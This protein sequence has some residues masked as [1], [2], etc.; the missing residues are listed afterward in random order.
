MLLQSRMGE[1]HLLPALPATWPDGKVTGLRAR[2]GF[3]VDMEWKDGKL[4]AAAVQSLR[5]N[6]CRIR[7]GKTLRDVKIKEGAIYEWR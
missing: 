6:A 1:L 2:G 5:G 3:T 7:Y 4:T